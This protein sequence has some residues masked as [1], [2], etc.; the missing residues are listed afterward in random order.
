MPLTL[1]FLQSPNKIDSSCLN[2]K[3]SVYA[4]SILEEC[5]R[6]ALPKTLQIDQETW[7]PE[8]IRLFVQKPKKLLLPIPL[9]P[10]VPGSPVPLSRPP[11]IDKSIDRKS[12]RLN[13]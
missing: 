3:F 4:S 7:R 6:A 12:T 5:L 13:P 8:F 2:N 10:S 1:S 9:I 11:S